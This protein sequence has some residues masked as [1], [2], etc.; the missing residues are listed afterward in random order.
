MQEARYSVGS[1]ALYNRLGR[2]IGQL[3]FLGEPLAR[4]EASRDPDPIAARAA[5]EL[6]E[7]KHLTKMPMRERRQFSAA[8][9]LVRA[10]AHLHK[11]SLLAAALALVKS[12]S[13]APVA[14][15]ALTRVVHNRFARR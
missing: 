9:A 12:L 15:V 14:N 5:L 1:V 2:M 7:Q 3:G 10:S 4:V 6:M 11:G 8:V 13:I